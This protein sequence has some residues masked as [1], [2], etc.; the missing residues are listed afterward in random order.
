MLLL[1]PELPVRMRSRITIGLAAVCVVGGWAFS[2]TS[3]SAQLLPGDARKI[4]PGADLLS[5][6]K[7]PPDPT[8]TH[9]VRLLPGGGY[10]GGNIIIV[11]G[12]PCYAP[13]YY[14]GFV[15]GY[16]GYGGYYGGYNSSGYS[17]G[18]NAGGLSLG[19][20]QQNC[21]N[22]TVPVP[23]SVSYDYRQGY[24]Q[25]S[26]PDT[27]GRSDIRS[28]TRQD[29][30]RANDEQASNSARRTPL[31][32]KTGEDDSN[33][34]YLNRKTSPLQKEPGLAQAVKDIETAFRTANISLIEKHLDAGEKLTLMSQG[35]SRRQLE[36]PTYLEMTKDAF[37]SIKTV[38]YDLDKVEPASGG[39][40]MV[41]GKHVLRADNGTEQTFNVGFVL[42]KVTDKEGDFWIITEVSADPAK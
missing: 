11:N 14:G 19:Y 23:P 38:K 12:Q 20:R 17:V 4:Y 7:P 13:G 3:A 37:K 10:G 34:Y 15:G 5:R 21:Y 28:Q 16:G 1:L 40:W 39:A 2:A 42:K 33:D 25:Q 26:Y 41:Y 6:P 24:D 29:T 18:F 30:G 8:F 32:L 22:N 36:A 31:P 35:R 27:F 9:G